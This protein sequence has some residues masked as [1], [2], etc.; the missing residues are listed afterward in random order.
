MG[1]DLDSFLEFCDFVYSSAHNIDGEWVF[2]DTGVSKWK[3]NINDLNRLGRVTV[4][5]L[6]KDVKDKTVYHVQ[7]KTR[8]YFY[9]FWVAYSHDT[10]KYNDISLS[11]GMEDYERFVSDYWFLRRSSL[12]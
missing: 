10:Y 12:L 11:T 6:S 5:H 4:Y 7:L 3:V 2:V 1:V 9:A 8:S